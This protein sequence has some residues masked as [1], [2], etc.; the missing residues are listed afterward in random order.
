MKCVELSVEPKAASKKAGATAVLHAFCVKSDLLN[1][2]E[3]PDAAV[4]VAI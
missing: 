3:V 2:I 4:A 1:S